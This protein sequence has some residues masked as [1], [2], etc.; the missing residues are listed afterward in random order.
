MDVRRRQMKSGFAVNELL[1]GRMPA[2]LPSIYD[3]VK[4]VAWTK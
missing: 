4:R 2:F 1:Q 3:T